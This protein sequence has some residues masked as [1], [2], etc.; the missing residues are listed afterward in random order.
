MGAKCQEISKGQEDEYYWTHDGSDVLRESVPHSKLR[1]NIS[2]SQKQELLTQFY[3][4][5]FQ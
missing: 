3:A 2:Q 1:E 5:K 4:A